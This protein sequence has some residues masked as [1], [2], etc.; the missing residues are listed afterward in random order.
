MSGVYLSAQVAFLFFSGLP[1]WGLGTNSRAR[2]DVVA[3]AAGRFTCGSAA[4]F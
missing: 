1:F 2:E 3:V 4:V